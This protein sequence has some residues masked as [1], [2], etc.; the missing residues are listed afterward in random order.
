[1]LAEWANSLV[2]SDTLAD[3]LHVLTVE[4]VLDTLTYRSLR[5]A[6]IKAGLN[7]RAVIVDVTDLAVPAQSAWA[8]F[9]SARW[10]VGQLMD[11]R[12]VMVCG[13]G[14]KRRVIARN[15]VTRYIPVYPSVAAAVNELAKCAEPRV[16]QRARAR[17][18]AA[19]FSVAR[20]RQL[21]AE[22]LTGWSVPEFIPVVKMVVTVFVENV[23]AHTD[24]APSLRLE[25][26][27]QT[28]TVAVDDGSSVLPA[29]REQPEGGGDR[30]SGLA[31]VAALSRR[32]GSAP[33]SSGKTVWSVIGRENCV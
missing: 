32:W 3:G 22:W 8:A 21:A 31:I 26:D 29:R 30:V 18:P 14:P 16:R 9:T 20:S 12:I 6:I 5:D 33:T 15:G 4:G 7:D 28:V 13:S 23:L 17:L 1:V 27:G 2:V 24:S 19:E 10:H 25:S 11:T